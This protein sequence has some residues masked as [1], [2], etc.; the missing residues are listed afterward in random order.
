MCL[1]F[2]LGIQATAWRLCNRRRHDS[3]VVRPRCG[4]DQ[5]GTRD[6]ATS[7]RQQDP[8]R[9]GLFINIDTEFDVSDTR[10]HSHYPWLSKMSRDQ[11]DECIDQATAPFDFS[12]G[13]HFLFLVLPSGTTWPLATDMSRARSASLFQKVPSGPQSLGRTHSR[14]GGKQIP[15]P[16]NLP[17]EPVGIW[18]KEATDGAGL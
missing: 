3:H 16:N 11:R 7:A 15:Y 17:D 10:R 4:G 8:Q 6:P 1:P 5:D 18:Y 12:A 14:M 13:P 9:T 2:S